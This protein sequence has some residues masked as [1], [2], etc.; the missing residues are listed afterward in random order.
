M[1]RPLLCLFVYLFV[2]SGRKTTLTR[3]QHTIQMA[4]ELK[5]NREVWTAP[6][7]K[8]FSGSESVLFREKFANWGY[9]PPIQIQQVFDSRI[10]HFVTEARISHSSCLITGSEWQKRCQASNYTLRHGSCQ[11]ICQVSLSPFTFSHTSFQP[12]ISHTITY[13]GDEIRD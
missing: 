10:R 2:V 13:N 5:Q 3:R 1:T 6:I 12:T 8:E 4:T 7:S 11:G 9:G